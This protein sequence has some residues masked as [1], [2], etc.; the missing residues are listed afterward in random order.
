[1]NLTAENVHQCFINCL[2]NDNYDPEVANRTAVKVYGITMNIG[3]DP[4]KLKGNK[5]TIRALL[6][7]LPDEFRVNLGGGM[8]FLQ[9]CMTKDGTHWGEH[10]NME[11]LV[12]LGMAAGYMQECLPRAMWHVLPG[13]MPYY[14]VNISE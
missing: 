9:M 2:F 6:N 4:E 3:F 12:L 5:E 13:G 14:V 7:E 10:H 11:K 1:M 8:S